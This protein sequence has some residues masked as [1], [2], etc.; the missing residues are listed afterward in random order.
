MIGFLLVLIQM[1]ESTNDVSPS[2]VVDFYR[3]KLRFLRRPRWRPQNS[4]NSKPNG[5]PGIVG[6]CH[7]L[8][9]FTQTP[10]INNAINYTAVKNGDVN[11]GP[12][13]ASLRSIFL[14]I[15]SY[16]R[17]MIFRCGQFEILIMTGFIKLIFSQYFIKK[18]RGH[19][20][21]LFSKV[22]VSQII[23]LCY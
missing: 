21:H 4:N 18:L 5:V 15:N 6:L 1:L 23:S 8:E 20:A 11:W 14:V 10:Q 17:E 9:F 16:L 13:L 22:T 7:V 3:Y 2:C 19:S 12:G